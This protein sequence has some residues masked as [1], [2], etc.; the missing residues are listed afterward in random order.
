MDGDPRKEQG[1]FCVSCDL[2]GLATAKVREEDEASFIQSLQQYRALPRLPI[3]VDCG[4]RH[5]IGFH[6]LQ[7]LSLGK[8]G[9][10]LVDGI[11]RQILPAQTL[12]R[13]ILSK[14]AEVFRHEDI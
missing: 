13:I 11:L 5:G 14:L 1:D 9:L 6:H 8:P 10:E 2:L 3:F 12:S 7:F 4:Q